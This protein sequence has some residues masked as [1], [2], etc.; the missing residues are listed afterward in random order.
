MPYIQDHA[1][2]LVLLDSKEDKLD[3]KLAKLIELKNRRAKEQIDC[4]RS[5]ETINFNIPSRRQPSKDS[6]SSKVI[7]DEQ[8]QMPSRSSFEIVLKAGHIFHLTVV[9]QST[10]PTS[11][12]LIAYIAVKQSDKVYLMY[13]NS[14]LR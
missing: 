11:N 2:V 13:I 8:L 9:N 4:R 5:S 14:F 12:D 1:L 10:P 3:E 7:F 6:M